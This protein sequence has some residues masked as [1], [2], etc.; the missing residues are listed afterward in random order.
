MG[1]V[2]VVG[3]VCGVFVVIVVVDG[4]VMCVVG[5]KAVVVAA[6][7]ARRFDLN[8]SLHISLSAIIFCL[9]DRIDSGALTGSGVVGVI[10]GDGVVAVAPTRLL[11]DVNLA[12]ALCL[13][14]VIRSSGTRTQ[15]RSSQP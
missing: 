2:E 1:G 13:S 15:Y 12:L 14:A 7:F 11:F 9:W 3:C 10:V 8:R 5:A 4:V 6:A